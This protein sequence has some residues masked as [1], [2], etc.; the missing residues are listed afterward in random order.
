LAFTTV[1][2]SN[3]V[4]SLVGTSGIDTATIVTLASNVFVGGNTGNDVVTTALGTGGNNLSSY[5]VR[6]GGGDDT[7]TLG[8]TL[9]N[10]FL[11]LDGRT[12]ANDGNDTFTGVGNLII[13][14]EVVGRGGNDVFTGL[15]LNGSTVNGNTGNDNITIG[16]S[17]ASFVYGGADSDVIT[18]TALAAG[19]C[20]SVLIN[21]NKGS[22]SITLQASGF[23]SGSV[24]GGNGNDTIN[25][26]LV[27]DAAGVALLNTAAGVFISGDLGDDGIT[28]S[29]G[30]DTINGGDGTDT[31]AGG[32]GADIIN[33]GAG[34][35]RIT[36]GTQGDAQAGG[37]GND[38]F[39]VANGDSVVTAGA[40]STGFDSI[41]DF[42]ANTG[43][44]G[45]I[46]GDR[47]RF[48]TAAG[49]TAYQQNANFV[50]LGVSLLAD[51]TASEVAA[52]GFVGADDVFGVTI[53]GAVAWAGNYICFDQ[54]GDGVVTAAD[55]IIK[56][57]TLGGIVLNTFNAA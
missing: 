28:G 1:T 44:A 31:L 4:T 41:T 29:G 14:S 45:S 30:V 21:G 56:L 15:A 43:A 5:N 54:D 52:V 25:A 22:D 9:L 50:S 33:G 7:F 46:N 48:T 17:S 11:S 26:N 32:A 24:Y 8:D 19:A 38:I 37:A 13:N 55:E 3:G 20:S 12:L 49:V 36:G 27:T 53:T 42:A 18:N 35:D 16:A 2:G 10:S 34:N 47:I 23:A 39:T 57:N 51:L 6:M 40:P